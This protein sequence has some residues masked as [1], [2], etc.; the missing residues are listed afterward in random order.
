M[1]A[2]DRAYKQAYCKGRTCSH[3]RNWGGLG[4]RELSIDFGSIFVHF[5]DLIAG[6]DSFRG[7]NPETP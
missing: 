1:A 7:G 2:S 4:F 6:M 3:T 5:V